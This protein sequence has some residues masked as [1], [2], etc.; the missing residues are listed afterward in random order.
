MNKYSIPEPLVF[1]PL[2]HYLP[3]IKEFVNTNS[4]PAPAYSKELIRELKHI[5]T[6]VMD[7][8]SGPMVLEQICREASEFLYSRQII[9]KEVFSKWAG[10]DHNSFKIVSFSDT[11]QWTFKY[12]ENDVRYVHIFPARSSPY[13]FRV[14]ANTLISAILYLITVGKDYVT[15]DDLNRARALTGLSPVKDVAETEAVTEMID[16]LRD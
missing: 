6:C 11:S 15:E 12:H 4:S 3:Y 8:Y 10:T 9:G 2:K 13:T 7:V 14:K 1:N 5:G 16:I